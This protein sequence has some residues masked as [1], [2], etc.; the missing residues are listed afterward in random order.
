MRR[1]STAVVIQQ[2][3]TRTVLVVDDEEHILEKIRTW[4]ALAGWD[5]VCVRTVSE[6]LDVSRGPALTLALIDY[7]LDTGDDGIRLGRVL[8]RRRGLPFILLSGFLDTDLAVAAIKAGAKDAIKKPLTEARLVES[9]EAAVAAQA[10]LRFRTAHDAEEVPVY[11]LAPALTRWSRAILRTCRAPADPSTVALWV[12]CLNVSNRFMREICLLCHVNVNAS[13]DFARF[14]RAIARSRL[15]DEPLENQ[16]TVADHRTLNCLFNK[17]GLNRRARTVDVQEFF[18]NQTFIPTSRPCL[19]ELTHMA[20][21]SP[22]F[23]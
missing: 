2:Q 9:I 19:R 22:F 15:T 17:A 13:C 5:C 8:R 23:F 20:A 12:E 10:R 3:P 14:V 21:N 7:R 6:A 4:L 16:F 1:S 18:I 11:E